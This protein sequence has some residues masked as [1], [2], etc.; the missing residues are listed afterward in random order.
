MSSVP[1][2]RLLPVHVANKIAAGEVV[3]RP[4]SV[5]KEL[6]ENSLDAGAKNINVDI[7]AGGRKLVA[8]ND[9]GRGMGRDDAILSLERQATSKI[10]DVDDIE[11]IHTLGFRGEALAAIASVSRFRLVTRPKEDKEGTEILVTAGKM[12]DVEDAGCPVGTTI[13]VRDLFHNVP[14][15]R[16]FLRTHQTEMSH[17]RQVFMVQALAHPETGMSLKVD[18]RDLYRLAGSSLEDR[19][20]DLFGPEYIGNLKPIDHDG[21][22]VVAKGYAG[23]PTVSRSDRGEQYIFVNGRATSA[24]ILAYAIREGYHTLLPDKRHPALFLFLEMA[25]DLVDVNVHPTKKEV[26]FRHPSAVRDTVIEAIRNS[27]ASS[28]DGPTVA[29]ASQPSQK[30]IRQP[31]LKIANLPETREFQYPRQS[32]NPEQPEMSPQVDQ[33]ELP[34]PHATLP[35][36]NAPWSFCRVLGQVGGLYVVLETDDGYVMM[37]PHA[38]H[39]RVLFEKFLNDV[40]AASV[41]AQNL[42]MPETVELGPADAQRV[43]KNL[44]LLKDMGFG[45]SEFGGDAFVVDAMPSYFAAASATSV[46]GEVSVEL[47][48]VGAR[49]GK[50]RWREEAIAQAA[51]KASVRARDKLDVKEIEQLVVDLA[52]AEMPYTCPHGRPTLI[53]TSFKELNRKFGRE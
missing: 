21:G 35:T 33:S 29:I 28:G 38:A 10:S 1:H 6:L 9:D 20:C 25:P 24:P 40:I 8:V 41:Q 32:F 4:A 15:R 2:I 16:K 45:I 13:E 23:V 19:V 53:Y 31:M 49:G 26:R 12:R 48:R 30:P 46:I 42:L 14:A 36:Q 7:V 43:R 22:E 34:T 27:L 18:G 17:V 37:D 5:L 50:G 47:E 3:E 11:R 44:D 52:K 39:E 51:C